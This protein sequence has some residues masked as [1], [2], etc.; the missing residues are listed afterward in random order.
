MTILLGAWVMLFAALF[1]AYGVVRVQANEWPPFGAPRLPRGVPALNTL[2][3]LASSVALRRGLARA[4]RVA[5]RRRRAA[6]P[7]AAAVAATALLGTALPG[8]ADRDLAGDARA[9]PAARARGSTA[10]SSSR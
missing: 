7:R 3:L 9:R 2:L 6:A 1:L 8:G 5:Q 10:R 4:R